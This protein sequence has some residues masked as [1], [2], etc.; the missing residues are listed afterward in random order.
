MKRSF[1]IA[2]GGLAVLLAWYIAADRITP[3]TGN[4]R[5]KAVITPITPQVSGTVIEIAAQNGT[6]V[7][8]GALLAQ[9]DPRPYEIRKARAE[10]DLEQAT[11]NVGAESADVAS[12]QARLSRAE[13]D[14]ETE[15]LQSARVFDLEAKGL[16]AVAKGDE[17]RRRLSEAEA[18]VERA[19]ADL[20]SEK[21]K[22]GDTGQDNPRIR[23]ALSDLADA[24]LKLG[25]TTL[26]APAR[27][28][29]SDLDIAAGSYATAGK[30]LMTFVDSTDIW[31]EAYLTENNIG[32]IKVGDPVEVVLDIHPGRIL[33]GQ[34]AS[35]SAAA[36]DGTNT[37]PGQPASVPRV[38]GW[39]RDPQRFP[40][41]IILPGH[42]RADETDD[43]R[44]QLNG[45]ADVIVF[46]GN[47]ALLNTIGRGYIRLVALF[48]YVY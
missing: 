29:V 31:I 28:I 47:S 23:A 34:I 20:E 37:T 12:A 3:F 5:V 14:L 11:Q 15:K 21:A 48:S 4:A 40:V 17:S 18:N 2:L 32:R 45:Q 43:L 9:I 27:G 41:R 35:F 25:W 13:T 44:F 33:K 24:E 42:T 19:R 10:A 1:W 38:S 46:T 8:S 16:V 6:I 39:L 26:R 36:S 30:N 7:E 22:L